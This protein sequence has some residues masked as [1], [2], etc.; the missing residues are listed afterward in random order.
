MISR[1][2]ICQELK[3]LK[4]DY[5]ICES[6]FRKMRDREIKVF[7]EHYHS[8]ISDIEGFNKLIKKELGTKV[9]KEKVKKLLGY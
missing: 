9:T 6:C 1:C 5:F 8:P 7:A 4:K 3:K 2:Q